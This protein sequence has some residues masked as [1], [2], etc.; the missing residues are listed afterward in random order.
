M[1]IKLTYGRGDQWFEFSEKE[2]I[3][4]AQALHLVRDRHPDVH[5][6][7]CDSE[8]RL[9][10]SLT[11]FVNRKHIRYSKGIETE[12]KDG[13]EVYVVPIAAGG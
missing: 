1:R 2:L 5:K 9:R 8:G 11:V 7:W 4:V 6:R 13:D 12:I 10:P 3:K